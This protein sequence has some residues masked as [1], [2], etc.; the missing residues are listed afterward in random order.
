MKKIIFIVIILSILSIV[1]LS[2]GGCSKSK[3]VSEKTDEPKVEIVLDTKEA[4]TMKLAEMNINVPEKML[5]KN[6]QK[7]PYLDKDYNEAISHVI[8]FQIDNIDEATKNEMYDWH[9]SQFSKLVADGWTENSYRKNVEMVSGGV[10]SSYTLTKASI[11]CK[12]RINISYN[13]ENNCSISI[14]P[15]FGL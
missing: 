1:V 9:D 6:L 13:S 3:N 12:I 5:F 10:F 7:S 4:I 14:N 8:Y 2:F 11:D 15:Q